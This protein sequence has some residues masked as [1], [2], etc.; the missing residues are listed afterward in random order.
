MPTTTTTPIRLRWWWLLI[1][2]PALLHGWLLYRHAVNAPRLDDF[3]EILTFLPAW[4]QA[5]DW[6]DKLTLLFRDY[7]NHRYVL[8][9]VLLTAFDHINFRDATWAGNVA[10]PLLCALMLWLT[11]T[12]PQRLV[13]WL[14]A[15]WLVFNLQTWR[16]MFWGPLGTTNLLYPTVALLACWLATRGTVGIAGAAVCALMLTLS[17]GSGPLLFPV[18]ALYLHC[19]HRPALPPWLLLTAVVFLCYFVLFPL[20]SE[21]GYRSQPTLELLQQS[22]ATPARMLGGFSAMLGSHLLYNDN[23]AWWK[24]GCAIAIGIIEC[25]AMVWLLRQGALRH[26]PALRYWMLFLLLASAS[27]AIG[28]SAYG[29]IDQSLQGHYKLMNGLWLWLL[30]TTTLQW[31]HDKHP[32]TLQR[33]PIAPC[34]AGL[35]M[36]LFGLS[37]ALFLAPTQTLQQDLA[38]DAKQFLNTG[39]LHQAETVLY[40]KQPNKKIKAAIDGGFYDPTE[41]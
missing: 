34:C 7:Q 20:Q 24:T 25:I 32:L 3:A 39:K 28:R 14:C 8:Y 27:I 40:V 22:L 17:H 13:V 21:A 11:R 1:L 37:W 4:H 41:Q 9:H 19:H 35:A 10:L 12:H 30:I 15:T 2:A 38:N 6:S 29:G 31:L 16:A 33:L 5:A 23:Q 18:I 26:Y 36:A